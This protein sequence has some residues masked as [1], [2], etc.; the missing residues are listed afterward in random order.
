[1]LPEQIYASSGSSN[2]FK[3]S[4]PLS[5]GTVDDSALRARLAYDLMSF[6]ER[7]D[8]AYFLSPDSLET[9]S[10]EVDIM[11]VDGFYKEAEMV[12][13]Q[14][15]RED[16]S[17]EKAQ[18]QKAFIEHLRHEYENLLAQE[19]RILA[20]DPHNVNALINKGFAL[21]NLNREEEALDVVSKAQQ[22]EPDNVVALSNKA[23]I[24]KLLGKDQV[25]D[26]ALAQAYNVAAK[27]RIA[28]I[29]QQEAALLYD[30]GSKFITD[31]VPSAYD[32]FNKHNGI[33]H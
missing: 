11:I 3:Y 14:R 28:E 30:F 5:H 6:M 4:H 26:I 8:C 25:H 13:Q 19:E 17:D 27:Q 20:S 23:Y 15:L 10:D 29:A 33:V 9:S 1:M 7:S 24:A 18:F 32:A 16:P 22:L 31:G 12:I 2:T 21:A